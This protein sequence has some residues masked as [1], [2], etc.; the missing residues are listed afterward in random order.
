MATGTRN[1]IPL[2]VTTDAD[3][4]ARN[5]VPYLI[6]QDL[7]NTLFVGPG[8]L[9][10]TIQSALDAAVAGGASLT[11]RYT[12]FYDENVEPT[13]TSA[14][15]VDVVPLSD[16]WQA[17]RPEYEHLA[18]MPLETN[19]FTPY[20]APLMAIKCD[21]SGI[22]WSTPDATVFPSA[23]YG[24]V[25]S[26]LD[27]AARFGIPISFGYR[28]DRLPGSAEMMTTAGLRKYAWI[29]G[30]TL[31]SHGVTNTVPTTVAGMLQETLG[32]NAA[33]AALT[34]ATYTGFPNSQNLGLVGRGFYYRSTW[35]GIGD[36]NA[37]ADTTGWIARLIRRT[38]EF[39]LC[40]L[41]MASRSH[42]HF[43]HSLVQNANSV[44][45][46]HGDDITNWLLA[47]T[48]QEDCILSI[49][50]SVKA[51]GVTQADFAM[52]S[53]QFKTL[54]DI[55]VALRDAGKLHVVSAATFFSAVK[56]CGSWPLQRGGD[57]EGFANIAALKAATG[58]TTSVG[59]GNTIDIATDGDPAN[60]FVRM[61]RTEA[62]GNCKLTMPLHTYCVLRP[63]RTHVLKFK[64]RWNTAIP[65]VKPIFCFGDYTHDATYDEGAVLP[66]ALNPLAPDTE[67]E[68][69]THRVTFMMPSWAVYAFVIFS[70]TSDDTVFDIDDVCAPVVA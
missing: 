46:S 21:V 65:T 36:V 17:D 69:V 27:Y 32:M 35:T 15:G 64:T 68:W 7:P 31:D 6:S 29:G 45:G 48:P 14:P 13:W 55:I 60:T 9:Y 28:G 67:G 63:G 38:T 4:T 41:G 70:L 2:Y 34:D 8:M 23:T 54:I 20:D 56:G 37:L 11:N 16:V 62:A 43:G 52:S 1:L 50:G 5:E 58:W 25:L 57:C 39:S 18:G 19:L 53:A 42:R 40:G 30:V 12:V 26:C 49:D 59:T 47:G 33:I 44:D 3:A 24:S 22:S 61:T 10:T 66:I 51:T